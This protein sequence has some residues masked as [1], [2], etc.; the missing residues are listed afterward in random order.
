MNA[1]ARFFV[2]I[3]ALLLSL[4]TALGAYAAHGLERWLAPDAVA[5]FRT[6]VEYHFYHGLG[7]LAVALLIDR[8][9]TRRLLIIAAWL[10]V[11]GTVLF[12]GSL[13]LLA[14]VRASFLGPITPLGGVCFIAAW[15]CLA[16][17]ALISDVRREPGR[18][19]SADTSGPQ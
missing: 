3:S 14:F 10:M 19:Q 15:L 4:A 18:T 1:H 9:E 5:T 7:L 17:A 11:T 12:S 8:F 16:Y 13:Y 2:L 6:G